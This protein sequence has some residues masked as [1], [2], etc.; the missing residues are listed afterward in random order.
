MFWSND[1]ILFFLPFSYSA[2][3]IYVLSR[4]ADPSIAAEHSPET[5]NGHSLIL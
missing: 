5:G 1:L 3:A 4:A 2:I